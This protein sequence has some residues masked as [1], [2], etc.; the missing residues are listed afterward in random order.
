MIGRQLDE[1]IVDLG[2]IV[3]DGHGVAQSIDHAVA[4]GTV[5][6]QRIAAANAA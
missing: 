6:G 5:A 1:I 3:H 2:K 4:E